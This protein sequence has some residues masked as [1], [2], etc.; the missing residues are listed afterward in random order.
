MSGPWDFCPLHFSPW[1]AC[2]T[3]LYLNFSGKHLVRL[4]LT[5]EDKVPLSIAMYSVTQLS[6][7]EQCRFILQ[8]CM[9]LCRVNEL[10]QGLKWQDSHTGGEPGGTHYMV[11]TQLHTRRVMAVY[12]PPTFHN[13][14]I[15][16]I[17]KRGPKPRWFFL[18]SRSY[19]PLNLNCF[20]LTITLYMENS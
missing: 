8:I 9:Q 10:A 18:P 3:E 1:L 17:R 15:L 5:C 20:F 13:M 16:F 11:H 14:S 4:Q 7:L 12:P 2:S 6:E 19:E